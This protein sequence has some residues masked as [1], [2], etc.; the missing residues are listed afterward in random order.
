MDELLSRVRERLVPNQKQVDLDP[1]AQMSEKRQAARAYNTALEQALLLMLNVEQLRR[2][3]DAEGLRAMAQEEQEHLYSLL[4]NILGE[5]HACE[6][7]WQQGVG[8]DIEALGSS[9]NAT[10]A[11]RGWGDSSTNEAEG[12]S[13]RG[14]S[15]RADAEREPT[16]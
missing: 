2:V 11:R 10:D 15:L 1:L 6:A 9:V 5:L 7:T 8:A 3:L 12:G 4:R 16:S 13:I 14:P